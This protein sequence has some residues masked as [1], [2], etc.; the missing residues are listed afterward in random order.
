MRINVMLNVSDLPTAVSYI[1]TTKVRGFFK[2]ELC[3]FLKPLFFD[4]NIILFR[5]LRQII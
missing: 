4:P 1:M 3:F 5:R 2:C